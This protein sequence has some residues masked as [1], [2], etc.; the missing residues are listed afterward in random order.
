MINK[1]SDIKIGQDYIILLINDKK[2][3][4]KCIVK[5][6]INETKEFSSD[7]TEIYVDIFQ[8]GKWYSSNLLYFS[9]IGIGE[10]KEEALKNYN[11]FSFE[12]NPN[13]SRS[14]ED[15]K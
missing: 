14:F 10:N 11:R 1:I 2:F 3:A 7:K 4:R 15:V 5:A 8:R 6:I 13:F 12:N 9:E